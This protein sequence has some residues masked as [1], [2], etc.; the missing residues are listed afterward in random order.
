MGSHV[1]DRVAIVVGATV[2][3]PNTRGNVELSLTYHCSLAS[4]LILP[5]IWPHEDGRLPV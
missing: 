2:S 4:G 5:G 3:T 1:E